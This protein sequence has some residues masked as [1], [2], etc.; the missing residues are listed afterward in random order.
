MWGQYVGSIRRRSSWLMCELSTVYW[1]FAFIFIFCY[2]LV[3]S[4]VTSAQTGQAFRQDDRQ[5]KA[6]ILF[7][8]NVHLHHVHRTYF[9]WVLHFLMVSCWCSFCSLINTSRPPSN[10]CPTLLY[11][12]LRLS[13]PSLPCKLDQGCK[14]SR[15]MELA[16]FPSQFALPY[17]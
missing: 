10:L 12:L 13:Y 16:H 2:Q 1:Y 17:A 3:E 9:W 5:T 15:E 6:W 8:Q 4:W 7:T 11:S 14:V